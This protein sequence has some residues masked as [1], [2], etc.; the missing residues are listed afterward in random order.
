MDYKYTLINFNVGQ[1][2]SSTFHLDWVI[3]P[4]LESTLL[5]YE[6]NNVVYCIYFFLADGDQDSI[7]SSV[8]AVQALPP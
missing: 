1:I 3:V 6:I 5:W 4:A 8:P 7:L 2:H